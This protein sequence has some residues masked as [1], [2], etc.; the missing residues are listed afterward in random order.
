MPVTARRQRMPMPVGEV[1]VVRIAAE[2]LPATVPDLHSL[3][4]G[5]LPVS[6]RVGEPVSTECPALAGEHK[7]EIAVA[8]R[9]DTASPDPALFRPI[10]VNPSPEIL[11]DLR[12]PVLPALK[13]C[14]EV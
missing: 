2:S 6:D 14:A 10:L 9:P 11:G 12:K 4:D 7:P 5:V 13:H 1:E 3:G 8:A